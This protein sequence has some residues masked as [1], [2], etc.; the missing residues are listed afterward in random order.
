MPTM[1][2]TT[3]KTI[4]PITTWYNGA[5]VAASVF[6]LQC[7]GDNLSNQATFN[8]SLYTLNESGYL[9]FTVSQGYITMS[10]EDYEGWQTNEY[11][12]EWAATNLHITVTGD[13]TPPVPVPP[14]PIP[15][16]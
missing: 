12:F 6:Y 4:T 2:N 7:T 3:F 14:T 10:G 9:Q 1:S 13:Y 11:A 8:Y 5:E 15:P 16:M